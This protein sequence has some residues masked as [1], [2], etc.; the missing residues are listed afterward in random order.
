MPNPESPPDGPEK[1]KELFQMAAFYKRLFNRVDGKVV[2]EDLCAKFGYG[3]SEMGAQTD[4]SEIVA[5]K[6]AMKQTLYYIEE[7]RD[8]KAPKELRKQGT[9]ITADEL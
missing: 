1:Q 4:P 6:V 5:R 2:W 7:M 8:M 9:A 3:R